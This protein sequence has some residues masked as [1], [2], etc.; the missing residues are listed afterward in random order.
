MDNASNLTSSNKVSN[1]LSENKL[2]T[3]HMTI[4]KYIKYLCNAFDIR[5]KKYLETYRQLD[6]IAYSY[7]M[8]LKQLDMIAD[9]WKEK[10]LRVKNPALFFLCTI[11]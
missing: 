1:I 9:G 10:Q 3:N 5:G 8:I 4:G 7:E 6:D 2:A 11:R